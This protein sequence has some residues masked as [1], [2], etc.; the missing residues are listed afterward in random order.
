MWTAASTLNQPVMAMSPKRRPTMNCENRDRDV[1]DTE[2]NREYARDR[3]CPNKYL[4][5][6]A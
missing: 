3:E 5:T 1:N 2:R 6:H 4:A